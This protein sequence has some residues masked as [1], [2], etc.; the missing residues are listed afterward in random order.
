MC[1]EIFFKIDTYLSSVSAKINDI[2]FFANLIQLQQ[3]M[4]DFSKQQEAVW[5]Q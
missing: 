3:T 4:H 5:Q 2:T 1:P